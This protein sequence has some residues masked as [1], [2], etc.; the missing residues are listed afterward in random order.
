MYR[1]QAG[2]CISAQANAEKI[3]GSAEISRKFCGLRSRRN[4]FLKYLI[5]TIKM[6]NKPIVPVKLGEV[7]YAYSVL[8]EKIDEVSPMRDFESNLIQKD[9]RF[10]EYFNENS[11]KYELNYHKI[12]VDKLGSQKN[13]IEAAL[14]FSFEKVR[15]IFKNSP[16]S[17]L[18]PC[19][20]FAELDNAYAIF[21]RGIDNVLADI[22]KEKLN[23]IKSIDSGICDMIDHADLLSMTDEEDCEDYIL[24]RLAIAKKEGKDLTRMTPDCIE[25]LL[26]YVKKSRQKS[27]NS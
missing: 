20:I 18:P 5:L 25:F 11:N 22:E 19:M 2:F 7:V 4:K 1:C 12:I 23:D 24:Q 9:I 26:G 16:L 10:F 15:D 14:R 6:T 21:Y 8:D 13:T 17:L 27:D 3:G